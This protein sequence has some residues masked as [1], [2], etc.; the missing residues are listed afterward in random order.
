MRAEI[1]FLLTV[2][3]II[4]VF[5]CTQQSEVSESGTPTPTPTTSTTSDITTPSQENKSTTEDLEM[6]IEE[7]MNELNQIEELE[8][9]ANELDNI[10]FDI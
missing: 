2:L 6:S 7:L 8:Q 4:A 1:V 5:G 9:T 3:A 10:N